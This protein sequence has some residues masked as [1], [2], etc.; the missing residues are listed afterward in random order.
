MNC[1]TGPYVIR[2]LCKNW[3]ILLKF[4]LADGCLS[5]QLG[6]KRHKATQYA[7]LA[8]RLSVTPVPDALLTA[9]SSI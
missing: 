2:G 9:K 4:G 5:R 6:L 1:I 7:F 3:M 8:R